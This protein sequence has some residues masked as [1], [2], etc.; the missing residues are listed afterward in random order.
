MNTDA[1]LGAAP[2]RT[3]AVTVDKS[4]LITI[5]EK[6]YA[7]SIE[8]IREL[9]NNAYDADATVVRI[10]LTDDL[11]D[12]EDN[13]SGMDLEGLRQ[14][15]NIGSSEKR[16]HPRSGRLG[17]DRI[18]QFGIGKF[19]SLAAAGS[20]TVHTQQG[21]FAATVTF[22]KTQWAEQGESWEIPLVIRSADPTRGAGTTVSLTRLT[23]RFDPAE[24]ERRLIEAVPLRA[25]EFAV[26]VNGKALQPR[27]YPGQRIP[28]LEGTPFGPVH[29]EIVLVPSSQVS[30]TEPLGIEVKVKQVTVRRELFGME[31]WGR[32]IARVH[33]Q[34]HA[35]F[36][37]IT[38]DRS[39]FIV[40]GDEYRAFSSVMH[41]IMREVRSVLARQ[42]GERQTRTVRRALR[43]ALHRVQ[44]ALARH[45]DLAP[46]GMLPLAGEGSNL[47]GA[48]LIKPERPPSPSAEAPTET[49][50]APRPRKPRT[51]KP[52]AV[53]LTPNAVI[54]R[55]KLGHTG[56]TC[57]L[58]RFG[59]DSPECFTEGAV[60]YINLDHPLYKRQ[61]RSLDA[62]TMHLARL[63]AQEIA[64][65]KDPKDARGA[66]AR[67]S[68]LLRDAFQDA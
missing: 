36:L 17:R 43:D 21:A 62:H 7:E 39:G 28:F 49:T 11:I 23:R 41:R 45:P 18:G 24:V 44:S 68:Q 4:H 1:E 16:I 22:D 42:A 65:M 63:M 6:L 67:Q 10:T 26:F 61:L 38:S 37:P 50:T 53:A 14:Y 55:L 19:A 40:D 31:A 60:I 58:D 25:E 34:V 52:K 66:F 57:C 47:G 48:G 29:G 30:M 27:T 46:P 59:E 13:G 8:L 33:G 5:G 3:I 35:D 2:P 56:I 12:I 20:F 51:K 32:E 15:F 9:V 64:L 54:Q